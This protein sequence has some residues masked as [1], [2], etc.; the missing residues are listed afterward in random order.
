MGG[1]VW[2]EQF[3][4]G[5]PMIGEV[6]E[7]GVYDECSPKSRP[8]SRDELFE[9]AKDR[10][11]SDKTSNEPHRSK[12]WNEA[13]SQTEKGWLAGPHPYSSEG[14]LR[15][16]GEDVTVNPA[17]RFGAQQAE[18]LRAVDDLKRSSANE[19]TSVLTPINLPS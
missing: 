3:I 10:W 9:T 11:V 15:I 1:S 6:G 12:L 17:Y 16:G 4:R 19:A 13:L 18:K 8:L 7:P 5:F 14:K 2:I